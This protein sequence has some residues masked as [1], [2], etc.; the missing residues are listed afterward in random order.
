M[1]EE[2]KNAIED[3]DRLANGIDMSCITARQ[4]KTI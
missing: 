2:E 3:M 1:N 4:I